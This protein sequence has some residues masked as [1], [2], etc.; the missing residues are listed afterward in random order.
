MI[1]YLF[2]ASTSSHTIRFN[3]RK[4]IHCSLDEYTAYTCMHTGSS[5][6]IKLELN[7]N[8]ICHTCGVMSK[9]K[10]NYTLTLSTSNGSHFTGA[11]KEVIA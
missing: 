5:K 6:T 1:Q 3:R 2:L 9:E 7:I 4:T 10:K 8:L 11:G